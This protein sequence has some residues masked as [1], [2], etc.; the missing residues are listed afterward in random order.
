M[1]WILPNPLFPMT[2]PPMPT[3]PYMPT[4]QPQGCGGCCRCCRCCCRYQ[5]CP[6]TGWTA[7][8]TTTNQE[9]SS[10]DE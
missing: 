7:T 5:H 3:Y 1:T 4:P 2:I 8:V 9:A 10:D 6:A